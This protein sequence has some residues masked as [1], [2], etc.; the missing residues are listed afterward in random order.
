MKKHIKIDN[1]WKILN[2]G[3]VVA[4]A[5]QLDKVIDFKGIAETIGE[6]GIKT[7]FG[8]EE[9]AVA[10]GTGL[11]KFTVEWAEA[12]GWMVGSAGVVADI[13]KGAGSLNYGLTVFFYYNPSEY[14]QGH[15]CAAYYNGKEAVDKF[16]TYALYNLSEFRSPRDNEGI[17]KGMLTFDRDFVWHV[18]LEFLGC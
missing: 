16:G 10:I 8:V 14:V 5:K 4:L 15:Q 9:A 7:A 12:V 6:F 3:G 2:E 17:Q 18:L 1:A 11:A 13:M